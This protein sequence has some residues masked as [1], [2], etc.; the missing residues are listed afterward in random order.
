MIFTFFLGPVTHLV[1]GND[2]QMGNDWVEIFLLEWNKHLKMK[3]SRKK[4]L[5]LIRFMTEKLVDWVFGEDRLFCVFVN[6]FLS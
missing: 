5:D 1:D 4:P 2:L 6:H 3:L